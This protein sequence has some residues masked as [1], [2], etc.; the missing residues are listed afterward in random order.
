MKG[1]LA[2]EVANEATGNAGPS[3]DHG[4]GHIK[5]SVFGPRRMGWPTKGSGHN[6]NSNAGV[7]AFIGA[8]TQKVLMAHIYCKR[9]KVCENAKLKNTPPNKHDC[10]QNYD[11]HLSSKSMEPTAILLM[12]TEAPYKRGLLC[13]GSFQTM[14]PCGYRYLH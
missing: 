5:Q 12:A 7:G 2:S 13:T 1:A 4:P 10:V 9:C 6:Y 8:Y 14:T 3:M 11:T